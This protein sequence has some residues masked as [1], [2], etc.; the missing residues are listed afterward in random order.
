MDSDFQPSSPSALDPPPGIEVARNHRLHASGQALLFDVQ[1]RVRRGYRFWV[2]G[3]VEAARILGLVAK[4]SSLHGTHLSSVQRH[5]QKASGEA[6]VLFVWPIRNDPSGYT[7]RFGFLLLGTANLDGERMQDGRHKPVRV[8]LYRTSATEF[9]LVPTQ[10]PWQRGQ[11]RKG[12]P[13]VDY[14]WRLAPRAEQTLRER[15]ETAAR[16]DAPSFLKLFET[17]RALPLVAGYRAQLKEA[18]TAARPAWKRNTQPAAQQ[19]RARMKEGTLA[20]PFRTPLPFVSGF[21]KM[22]SDPAET[23]ADHLATAARMRAQIKRA[24]TLRMKALHEQPE[25]AEPK[26]YHE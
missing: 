1:R 11:S 18:V 5:R 21:P 4:L 8:N 7:T 26:E 24:Q 10:R 12:G 20:D 23:L 22:Y 9:H 14:V 16:S 17:Y 15:L 2:T 25:P 19:L 13:E 3:E 6:A